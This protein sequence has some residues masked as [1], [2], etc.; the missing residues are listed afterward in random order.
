MLKL[1]VTLESIDPVLTASLIY[2]SPHFKNT[3]PDEF[4]VDD[5]EKKF[6]EN[7]I[8]LFAKNCKYSANHFWGE[9]GDRTFS[10]KRDGALSF[11]IKNFWEN[12]QQVIEFLK[13]YPW[14]V[15][16]LS[17]IHK[18]WYSQ[19]IGY[20]GPGFS[21]RHGPLGWGC[22]FKGEGHKRVVSRRYLEYGPWHVIR[23]EANDVT[24]IQFHDLNADP[25]TALEQAKPGHQL[26][27][28]PFEGGFIQRDYQIA[29]E[30]SAIYTPEERKLTYTVNQRPVTKSELLDVCATRLWQLLGADK[31]VERVSYLFIYEEDARK[32]LHD[33]WL[34]EIE[35]WA[36]IDGLPVRLDEN[37]TPPPPDKPEWVQ[38]LE[39]QQPKQTKPT[40][41]KKRS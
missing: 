20:G 13:P 41:R 16:T 15:A 29:N 39:P 33:L 19:E 23:D 4:V 9:W 35:C 32:H 8:E 24:L 11:S 3:P 40:T 22:A 12:V 27:G 21:Y 37:Y 25:L 30:L 18:S 1:G 17:S 31:P 6:V 5:E 14:T 2:G 36:F 38:Q 28:H 10:Y 7:W 34:R 26:M